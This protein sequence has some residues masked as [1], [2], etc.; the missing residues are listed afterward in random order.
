MGH[1]SPLLL[2]KDKYNLIIDTERYWPKFHRLVDADV[3]YDID[4]EANGCRGVKS[5]VI[6]LLWHI[7]SNF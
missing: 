6:Q 5:C 4:M 1:F 2:L 3:M 7:A